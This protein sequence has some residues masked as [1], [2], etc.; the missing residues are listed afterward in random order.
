MKVQVFGRTS[1]L[2]RECAQFT[3]NRYLRTQESQP[4]KTSSCSGIDKV[5]CQLTA[6]PIALQQMI[7]LCATRNAR[8]SN[9]LKINL[10]F[11]STQNKLNLARVIEEDIRANKI[12]NNNPTVVGS[13]DRK[14]LTRSCGFE[15]LSK[16]SRRH[17]NPLSSGS[18]FIVNLTQT[19]LRKG[20]K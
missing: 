5:F 18:F 2:H 10:N 8:G 7:N 14:R 16:S 19:S 13:Y 15:S 17:R 9:K 12:R 4:S 3:L 20:K 11:D 1:L 6:F